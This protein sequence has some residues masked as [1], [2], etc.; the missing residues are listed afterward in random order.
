MATRDSSGVERRLVRLDGN[1]PRTPP[2]S[3]PAVRPRTC[4]RH[5]RSAMSVPRLVT[6]STAMYLDAF[7]ARY[8]YG[9]PQMPASTDKSGSGVSRDRDPI[10]SRIHPSAQK[11]RGTTDEDQAA[12]RR[13]VQRAATGSRRHH[14]LRLYPRVQQL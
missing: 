11:Q 7:L 5:S 1:R 8:L 14:G 12:A 2:R 4:V 9:P 3:I 13:D 6:R 10:C